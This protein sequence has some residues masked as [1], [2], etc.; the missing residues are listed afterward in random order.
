MGRDE[1]ESDQYRRETTQNIVDEYFPTPIEGMPFLNTV[2]YFDYDVY[3]D[4]PA[5]LTV[6]WVKWKQIQEESKFCQEKFEYGLGLVSTSTLDE[7]V[8]HVIMNG[9]DLSRFKSLKQVFHRLHLP[10][11]VTLEWIQ[12]CIG[13]NTLVNE[14]GK[15]D[16]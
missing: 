4:P 13:N 10:R 5:P 1:K 3:K 9:K 7:G 2:A 14:L 12:A 11:F 6:E 8:T 16:I 15:I